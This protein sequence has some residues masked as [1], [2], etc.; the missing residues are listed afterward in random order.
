MKKF[1]LIAFFFSIMTNAISAQSLT[2]FTMELKGNEV[3]ATQ[4]IDA[5]FFG[6]YI[7]NEYSYKKIIVFM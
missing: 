6:S 1:I 4:N 2:T 7:K 5:K 3:L